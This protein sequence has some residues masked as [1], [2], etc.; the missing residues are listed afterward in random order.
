VAVPT[1]IT[2][3]LLIPASTRGL[4]RGNSTSRRIAPRDSPSASA[5]SRSGAG[6]LRKPACVFR[7]MGSKLYRNS[8]TMAGS[9]PM[10]NSGIMNTSSA[11][12]G[13]V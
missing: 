1:F 3:A 11:S 12:D 10:P 4:A 6:M 5:D 2:A 13:T 8:A 7:T 9:A